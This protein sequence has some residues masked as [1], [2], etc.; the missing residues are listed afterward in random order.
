VVKW[1]QRRSIIVAVSNITQN[2]EH[3]IHHASSK[4]TPSSPKAVYYSQSLE[5]LPH[6]STFRQ[7]KQLL[8]V[9]YSRMRTFVDQELRSP[10]GLI[11]TSQSSN[12]LPQQSL[13]PFL[14]EECSSRLPFHH[15]SRSCHWDWSSSTIHL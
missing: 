5:S 6:I 3:E 12:S 9:C 1:T 11:T 14:P 7:G 13:I 2:R 15:C 8:L 4:S 10:C